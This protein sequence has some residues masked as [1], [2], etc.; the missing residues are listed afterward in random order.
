MHKKIEKLVIQALRKRDQTIVNVLMKALIHTYNSSL[1]YVSMEADLLA[2][3]TICAFRKIACE[4]AYIEI[5]DR[6][7]IYQNQKDQ[8]GILAEMWFTGSQCEV[9]FDL[10]AN[11][12]GEMLYAM[13]RN[14]LENN[15]PEPQSH[16][17][18]TVMNVYEKVDDPS[19]EGHSLA[20]Q[21]AVHPFSTRGSQVVP[22]LQKFSYISVF[23][24][25][26][27]L[28]VILLLCFGQGMILSALMTPTELYII[29]I[30]LI[31]S[32]V[33]TSGNV[34]WIATSVMHHSY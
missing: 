5:S 9:Y 1:A 34:V 23:S 30:S 20:V 3:M 24:S 10:T 12:L 27:L 4:E 8:P 18:T 25:I 2:L 22:R 6:C 31:I 14:F 15:P 33:L 32:L 21:K 11:Q 16:N 28:E 13:R 19:M 7:P 29:T 17:A 26:A